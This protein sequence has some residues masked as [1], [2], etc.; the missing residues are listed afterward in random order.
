M[1]KMV[2]ARLHILIFILANF[3]IP[4]AV[5]ANTTISQGYIATTPIPPGALVSADANPG[6]VQPATTKNADSLLGVAL[7]PTALFSVTTSAKEVQVATAG[8]VPAM[9]TNY[10]GDIKVGDK[11]TASELSG[12]GAKATDTARVVG[13]AQGSFDKKTAGAVKTKVKNTKG[14]EQEVYVGQIPLLIG[15]SF[16]NKG[17]AE[18]TLVPS[19]LQNVAN[20]IA[21][22]QVAQLPI[23]I[24][25]AI[26]I[27][28]MMSA[29]VILYG[30]VRASIISLGRNPLSRSSIIGGLLQV[31]FLVVG[32]LV[33]GLAA[34]FLVLKFV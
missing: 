26:F 15:L 16:Y 17:E 34:I 4:A 7:G 31:G 25:L 24:S 33:V 3:L 27:I 18:K 23:V 12:F 2:I 5:F 29:F 13:V 14:K 6:V 9:V 30:T 22:K 1:Q 10:K 32:L 20:S 11:I 8:I 21:S 19:F 28:T